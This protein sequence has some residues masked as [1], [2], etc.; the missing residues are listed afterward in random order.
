MDLYKISIIL[1]VYN[2][3]KYLAQC[4]ESLLS[5][6]LE[7]IE[8]VAVD[9]GSTDKSPEILREYQMRFP[10]KLFLYTTKNHGVSHARNYGFS[11]S[12][13]QY[14]WFVDSDDYVEADACQ[15]LYQKA[16]SDNN[17]LVLFSY[18]NVDCTTL[19]RH[20]FSIA[21]CS[22]NFRIT[23][24]PCELPLISPYPWIKLIRRDLF[25][26]LSFPCGIR[27][28]DLPI[29]YL[30]AVKARCI[31]V[32]TDCL[33]NYRKNAGFLGSLVPST[34]DIQK[35]VLYLGE[36]MKKLGLYE[37]YQQELEFITV[38][39]FFYRFW[40]LLTNYEKGKRQIK[41]QLVCQLHDHLEKFHPNWRQNFYVQYFLPAHLYRML[42]LYGSRQE[43][44]A[45]VKACD[46]MEP[47]E[48]K[49][50]I[51]AYKSSHEAFVPTTSQQLLERE[52]PAQ[53]AYALAAQ[54]TP[55]KADRILLFS[56]EGSGPGSALLFLMKELF[57][58]NPKLTF[59]AALKDDGDSSLSRRISACLPE[60]ALTL[61]PP[62][63]PSLGQELASCGLILTDGPLPYYFQKQESQKVVLFCTESSLPLTA[64]THQGLTADTGLWQ[65]TL[66]KADLHVFPTLEIR[67]SYM[68]AS[69]L[70]GLCQTPYIILE[71]EAKKQKE[72]L[73]AP[74]RPDLPGLSPDSRIYLCCP[75][76]MGDTSRHSLQA[77]RSYLAA[78]CQM[79][80]EL[81]QDQVVFLDVLPSH[82]ADCPP[83][84]HIRPLPEGVTLY[85]LLPFAQ[86]LLT[87]HHPL[88]LPYKDLG[89]RVL[90]FLP[91]DSS[92]LYSQ[93]LE[94]AFCLRSVQA[95]RSF[96]ELRPFFFSEET[97][98]CQRTLSSI[99]EALRQ[100]ASFILGSDFSMACHP[101]KPL[102]QTSLYYVGKKLTSKLVKDFSQYA[103]QHPDTKFWLLY[104]D[105][106]TPDAAKALRHLETNCY[107]LPFRFHE[108][109]GS[110]WKMA[111]L[112]T[113]RLGLGRIY[114]IEPL[115]QSGREIYRRHLGSAVF[116]QVTITS[117]DSL[118][119]AAALMAAAP[120]VSYVFDTFRPEDYRT[121]RAY[122]NQ[123]RFLCRMLKDASFLDTPPQLCLDK[124]S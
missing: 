102:Y 15:K 22:Q 11:K 97:G 89:G 34:L 53:K 18:Y 5:Q 85:D 32:L 73:P 99:S 90:R 109:K 55:R 21:S 51:K 28:E 111:S 61:A 20:P 45:F 114:P 57:A 17:D 63:S 112:F 122:R 79:D 47:E 4:L 121:Q 14:I 1:P 52:A 70:F 106:K 33:Y 30:L 39:H 120:K 71:E 29:A 62:Q 42:Y 50:W 96:A 75:R 115:L 117:T 77:R 95:I 124:K 81:S 123:I 8:I 7:E 65:H 119:A 6:T 64:S 19:E 100:I 23:D 101:E 60:G 9:D 110:Q 68:E 46:G 116:D 43:M 86:G 36:N 88:A 59:V 54:K 38:R 74:K 82:M 26:G 105:F 91:P 13:G 80:Y 92:S 48:Q 58:Q 44:C 12:R 87:D 3:E 67:R 31:G 108:E 76:T 49:A 107:P 83:L 25:E 93:P 118:R 10:H 27:F 40:K 98:D 16:V 78:L 66:L 72:S 69:Q 84:R 37:T 104:H 94:E 41:E 35:A 103:S 2:V 56:Y 24:K 113:S